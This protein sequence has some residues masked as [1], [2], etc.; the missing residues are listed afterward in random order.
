MI[1][2]PGI[3]DISAAEYHADCCPM[4]SLSSSIAKLLVSPGGTPAHA[5]EAHPR[6]N[7]NYMTEE[8]EKFD[9]GT[10]A[11]ALILRD[12]AAFEIIEADDW[13]TK[14]AKDKRDEAR[15]A[16]KIPLLSH[17]WGDIND[18]VT[19][20]QLQ[21]AAHADA[22]G[23]FADGK[24]EQTLIW[25]EGD[26]WCRARL[27]WLPNKGPYFDDYKSTAASADP[28]VWDRAMFGMG[29]D[30]QAAFYLRGI[31]ALGLCDKPVFRF[32]VQEN[33]K[34]FALSVVAL[35]PGALDLASRDVEIA[36]RRWTDCL[37]HNRWPAYPTRTCYIDSPPW[38][39]AQKM[40]REVRE[41]DASQVEL[42]RAREAQAPI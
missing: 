28:D 23:A 30:F 6:L 3:Y 5:W 8:S 19:A 34:P 42:N 24:P 7:P 36:I 16:G 4:P 11:H 12:R 18:M 14:V 15:V 35:M 26:M 10:A 25:S 41:H 33:F 31:R 38:R 2:N 20:A 32:I 29:F 40:A 37:L 17:Q 22:S 27:D 1:E 39:E 21:L 9:L 13:R